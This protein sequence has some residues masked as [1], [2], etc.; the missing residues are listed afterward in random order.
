MEGI[1]FLMV[2]PLPLTGSSPLTFYD[3]PKQPE[4][5][6]NYTLDSARILARD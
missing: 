4:H 2:I 3:A 1:F 5:F 6:D